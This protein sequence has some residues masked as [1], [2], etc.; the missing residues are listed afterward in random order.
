[1]RLV[2]F[3]L[4]V[5]TWATAASATCSVRERAAVPVQ[6]I[7]GAILVPLQVDGVDATFILDTGAQRTVVTPAAVARLGLRLDEWVGT[8]MRGVGGVETHRNADPRSM[9]L[10]GML[11]QRHTLGHDIS[12][13]VG[14]LPQTHVGDQKIDGMLGRD[15]LSVFDLDLDLLRYTL[16]LYEVVDC[17]GHF[18]PWTRPYASVP[19]ANL[20]DGALVAQVAVNG[21]P[22]R[23][24]IDTGASS[25]VIG[26]PGMAR[27]GLTLNQLMQ[28]PGG[29]V[30]GQGPRMV[31]MRRHQFRSLRVGDET[32]QAP[33]LW[34][35]PIR[36]A[37]IVDMLLGA[38]W[39]AGKRVW[40]SYATTQVFVAR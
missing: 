7:A 8:T 30:S 18:L 25:S 20:M 24:L 26:A 11:L 23:A 22:M 40:I 19:V 28:D 38:D 3:V 39:L 10:G 31:I 13:A 34:V 4:M 35:A 12:L 1:M 33:E 5:L 21:I 17:G 15:F 29:T 9:T 6:D 32:I 37:P 16:T 36:F 14:T 2:F 27:L